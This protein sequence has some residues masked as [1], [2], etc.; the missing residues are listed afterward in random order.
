MKNWLKVKSNESPQ[1]IVNF[2][3]LIDLFK[4]DIIQPIKRPN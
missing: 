2:R 1:K 3:L 4:N